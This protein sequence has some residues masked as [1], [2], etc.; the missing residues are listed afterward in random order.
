MKLDLYIKTWCPWCHRAVDELNRLGYSYTVLDIE[1][2][3]QA[4]K[5][6]VALS[7]QSRVPT[8]TAGQ[9]VLPDFGPEELAPFFNKHGIV[10]TS[11]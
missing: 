10:V 11:K 6:M 2:D 5:Q 1:A 8:L 9:H 7:G 3:P 4:A